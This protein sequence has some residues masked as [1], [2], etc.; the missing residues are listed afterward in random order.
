MPVSAK[1]Y[2]KGCAIAFL[3][4]IFLLLTPVL[5]ERHYPEAAPVAAAFVWVTDSIACGL[6]SLIFLLASVLFVSLIIDARKGIASLCG[7]RPAIGPIS[8]E[9]GTAE[10]A[11]PTPPTGADAVAPAPAASEPGV[12]RKLLSLACFISFLTSQFSRVDIV[13]LQRPVLENLVFVALYLLRGCEVLFA[14]FLVLLFVAY[15]KL[16]STNAETAVQTPTLP[17]VSAQG[18]A[19]EVADTKEEKETETETEKN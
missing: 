16:K 10:P 4:T 19:A 3:G 12:F 2:V 7:A 5:I 14:G 18:I 13:S 6:S 17:V 9:E 1:A 15:L 8:L 11:A